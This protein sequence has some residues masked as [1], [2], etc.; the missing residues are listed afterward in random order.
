MLTPIET[1][2]KDVRVALIAYGETVE[3]MHSFDDPQ[4]KNA[5]MI[6][7]RKISCCD[8]DRYTGQAILAANKLLTNQLSDRSVH[9]ILL[10]D[11]VALD[12]LVAPAKILREKVTSIRAVGTFM[13]NYKDLLEKGRNCRF[14]KCKLYFYFLE[15]SL[16]RSSGDNDTESVLQM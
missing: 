15:F 11:G 10:T 3:T 9:V 5:V 6:A 1:G 7:T 12:D 14:Q 13:A 4:D 16:K 2:P 8:G